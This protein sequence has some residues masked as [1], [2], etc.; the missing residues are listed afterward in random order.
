MLAF[1]LAV[2]LLI[3]TP[4]PGVLST[5]GVGAG[6]GARTGAAYIAGLCLGN[7]LVGLAVATGLA[8]SLLAAPSWRL[9][10]MGLSTAYLLWLALR[11]ALAG[12]RTSFSA[13]TRAPR[14]WDGLLLQFVNPKAYAVNTVFFSS[15]A[16]LPDAFVLE[17]AVKFLVINCIWLP[18]HFL[19][20]YLGITLHS[21]ALRPLQQRAVNVAMALCL[22]AVSGLSAFSVLAAHG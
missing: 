7:N 13:A 21:L 9:A 4:G 19:W 16:F 5:A 6:F 15:F 14:W 3:I 20:L 8:A 1:A 12:A 22:A 18:L 17:T 11:I 10:F 2:F